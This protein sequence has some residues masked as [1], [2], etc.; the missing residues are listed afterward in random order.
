MT[1]K[2]RVLIVDDSAA[3]RSAFKRLLSSDPEIEVIAMAGDPFE[4]VDRMRTQVPDVILLDIE[5]PRMDGLTFLGKI[6]AQHPIPVVICSS[7][8]DKGSEA[9]LRALEMG[10][11]EVIGKPALGTEA[12]RQEAQIRLC[13]AVRAAAESD[14]HGRTRARPAVAR[15]LQPGPKLTADAV[16]PRLPARPIARRA[17]GAIVAIG[18]STGGTEAL[19]AVLQAL[20]ADAPPIVVVQHMPEKFTAAFARRLD[21]Q[22]R[23]TVAEAA[24]GDRPQPGLAL[25]APGD[26]HLILRRQGAG[27]RVE[28]AEG[29]YVA[30]HRPSV[31]VLFRSAAQTAGPNALGLLMTGMGDDG[32]RGLLEMR[33]AGA[34]T[35]VQ[36]EAS[37]VVFGMPREALRM[38]AAD[39]ALPL[40]RLAAEIMGWSSREASS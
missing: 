2:I 34:H 18:A 11:A 25:I 38:G 4:A 27:Y 37:S 13:D 10:A 26:R 31:D 12:Q 15:K 36:D 30:R 33:E 9:A 22:C 8:S 24:E 7:H 40:G 16:L 32:A 14:P 1:D 17:G 19:L 28:I 6:N 5:L 3:A 21:G 29:P 20:P 35:A 23:V 39:R